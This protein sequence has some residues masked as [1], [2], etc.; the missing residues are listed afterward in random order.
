MAYQSNF[1]HADDLVAH[2]NGIVP[3]VADAL[4]QAK[5]VGFVSIAAVTVYELALKEIFITFAEKK[6]K[7]FGSFTEAYFDR[8]NGRIQIDEISGQYIPRFGARYQK[9]FRKGVAE[10]AEEFLRTHGR[11]FRASYRNLIT[12]RHDFAHAGR[13]R[14]TATYAEVIQAYEDG[15]QVV[16]SVAEI[17]VR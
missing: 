5:Y 16:H 14:T 15:K 13:F 17:M 10:K 3:G 9:R 1:Q 6:H 11:D 4:L 12:W 2:L 8:I 7:V